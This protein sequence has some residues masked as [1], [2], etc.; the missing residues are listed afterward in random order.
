M[1][2][3]SVVS[4]YL[5]AFDFGIGDAIDAKLAEVW[6]KVTAWLTYY[7]AFGWLADVDPLYMW[8]GRLFMLWVAVGVVCWF[9]GGWWPRLRAIGG[10]MLAIAT[11]G[12]YTYYRGRRD[13]RRIEAA[14][15]TKAKRR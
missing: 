7:A 5:L 14:K 13:E 9:F 1:K 3:S 2:S 10:V 6:G 12:F 15:T 4:L 11:F 8:G